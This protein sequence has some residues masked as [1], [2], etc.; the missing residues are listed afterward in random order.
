LRKYRTAFEIVAR[1][2]VE[3]VFGS[4]PGSRASADMGESEVHQEE[5]IV[6]GSIDPF[7]GS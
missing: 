1:E 2:R 4:A 7:G 3:A 5:D 6:R